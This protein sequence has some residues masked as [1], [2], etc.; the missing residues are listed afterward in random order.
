ML[1]RLIFYF[2]CFLIVVIFIIKLYHHYKLQNRLYYPRSNRVKIP[3]SVTD[4][5]EIL[6]H[7]SLNNKSISIKGA[8]RSLGGQTYA[9]DS[10]QIDLNNFNRILG[11]THNTIT[12]ESGCTWKQI[13]DYLRPAGMSVE[14]MQSYSDFSVGGSLSVNCHGQDLN[15]NPIYYSVQSFRLLLASNEII[16]VKNTDE[17]FKYVIG[18]YGLF[19]IILDVTLTIIPN[20]SIMKEV[21]NVDIKDYALYLQSICDSDIVFHSGRLN[22]TSWKSCLVI[23]YKYLS[24]TVNNKPSNNKMKKVLNEG[25]YLGLISNYKKLGNIRTKKEMKLETRTDKIISRSD[26]LSASTSSLESFIYPT[27]NYVLQEYF[28]PLEHFTSFVSDLHLLVSEHNINLLNATFR[29]IKPHATILS[30]CQVPSIAIVLYIDLNKF[31]SVNYIK[32]WTQQI[33]AAALKYSGSYYLPYHLFATSEQF[34]QAYPNYSDC[35]QK[36]KQLDPTNLFT[37]HFWHFLQN[38][39]K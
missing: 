14:A 35:V 2:V 33:I 22:L 36:K 8:G 9:S 29:Y 3:T 10:I 25:F 23:N 5:R 6:H 31:S 15:F 24:E 34:K 12:V 38:V 4:L 21:L 20:Y 19:G 18:G 27:S 13:L 17:L 28:I 7:A 30:Y 32:H 16:H 1:F 39:K 37:S 11:M 26:F